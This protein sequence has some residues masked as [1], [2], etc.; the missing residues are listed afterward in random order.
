MAVINGTSGNDVLVGTSG[1]DVINGFDGNDQITGGAGADT[2]TGGAG[3]DTFIYLSSADSI[4]GNSDVITDFESGNDRISASFLTDVYISYSA[5]TSL[6]TDQTVVSGY[7]Q[8]Y[9]KIT[10]NGTVIGDDILP[11]AQRFILAG[12]SD[13]NII[14]GSNHADNYITGGAGQDTLTGGSGTNASTGAALINQFIFYT[15]DS[16][17]GTSD[18]ITNFVSGRDTLFLATEGH[19]SYTIQY[20]GDSSVIATDGFEVDIHGILHVSDIVIPPRTTYT[21]IADSLG[22]TLAGGVS[23]DQIVGGIGNDLIIGNGGGDVLTGGAGADTFKYLV[24]SDSSSSVPDLITDFQTGSDVID[25]AAVAPTQVSVIRSGGASFV[26]ASNAAGSMLIDVN[27]AVNAGDISWGTGHAGVYLVGDDRGDTLSGGVL[28]DAI[29]GGSGNDLIIGGA[30]A[31]GFYGGAGADTF[32]YTA[33][34]DSTASATDLILDFQTGTDKIDLAALAIN[35]ISTIDNGTAEFLFVET[36]SGA[37]LQIAAQGVEV[38]QAADFSVTGGTNFYIQGDSGNNTLIGGNGKDVLDGH[39]G[40]DL[41]IG[42]GGSD[43][44]FGG[45]GTDTFKYLAATD[46]TVAA[47]D[48]IFD[49]QTGIDKI[50]LTGVHATGVGSY[51]IA[52]TS[53]GSYLFVDVNGDGV[54]DMLIQFTNPN[55]HTSDILF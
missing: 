33:V 1:N 4:A 9:F 21:I 30:G 24:A 11:G 36:T 34:S 47:P 49:F 15:N 54:N 27:G 7:S 17:P 2:L 44:L 13:N 50:D 45:A 38:I 22:D 40:N 35:H 8:N 39:A 43:A 52:Y 48:T 10:I 42:G 6:I 23:N 51:G 53:T 3:S 32:K 14:V 12:S 16:K 5:G 28:G 26:F 46:S 29:H 18:T 20:Y 37:Q 41:I 55:L 31:D 25:L 19:I